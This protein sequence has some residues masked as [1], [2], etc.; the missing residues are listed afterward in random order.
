MNWNSAYTQLTHLIFGMVKDADNIYYCTKN[1]V[2][3]LCVGRDMAILFLVCS[4]V[5][6]PYL[7]LHTIHALDFWCSN[8]YCQHLLPYKKSGRWVVRRRISN[9][10]RRI[11]YPPWK[12][13]RTR[14]GKYYIDSKK[15]PQPTDLI[16]TASCA[17]SLTQY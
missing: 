15:M 4:I 3:G 16:L 7:R 9:E 5:K 12:N 13:R 10:A 14:P 8:R 11:S 2:R 1:L 6:W 17:I